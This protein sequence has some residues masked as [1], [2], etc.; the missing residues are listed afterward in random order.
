MERMG[1][2]ALEAFLNRE[3]PEALQR[4]IETQ[5]A[6]SEARLAS[7]GNRKRANKK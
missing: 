2:P 4:F 1:D 7:G 3:K 5:D 6:E